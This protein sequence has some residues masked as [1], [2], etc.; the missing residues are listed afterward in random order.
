MIDA[1][2]FSWT[3]FSIS[4]SSILPYTIC[5]SSPPQHV[6]VWVL[7][8]LAFAVLLLSVCQRPN[9]VECCWRQNHIPRTLL[10]SA[11]GKCCR[12][13]LRCVRDAI[14]F[15]IAWASRKAIPRPNANALSEKP[16]NYSHS[17]APSAN[18]PRIAQELKPHR[19]SAKSVPQLGANG[20]HLAWDAS[21]GMLPNL[22]RFLDAQLDTER[23]V[24]FLCCWRYIHEL[25]RVRQA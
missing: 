12:L 11:L 14:E 5:H 18:P 13:S 24:V 7:D 2:R 19:L 16:R 17:S 4:N 15:G 21:R 10:L 20:A 1:E 8:S 22:L 23:Y 6:L 9:V 25:I 3:K